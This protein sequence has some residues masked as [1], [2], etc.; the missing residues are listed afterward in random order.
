MFQTDSLEAGGTGDQGEAGREAGWGGL[1]RRQRD[2]AARRVPCKT[3]TPASD[4]TT[5]ILPLSLSPSSFTERPLVSLLLF[6]PN[7]SIMGSLGGAAV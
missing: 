5:H 4:W 6:Y 1:L 7:M 2:P 3:G